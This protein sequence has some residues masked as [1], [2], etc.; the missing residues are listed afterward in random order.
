MP[1]QSY[2]IPLESIHTNAVIYEIR[3]GDVYFKDINH[4][5]E[6][7]E[8][9][10][11][12]EAVG[13]RLLDLFPSAKDIGLYDGVLKVNENGI[14]TTLKV[15]FYE[16]DRI[17]GWRENHIAKI[18]QNLLLVTYSDR[19]SEMDQE[20]QKQKEIA[21]AI[22]VEK[23]RYKAFMKLSTQAIMITDMKGRLMEFSNQVSTLFG[24]NTQELKKLHIWDWDKQI[25]IEQIESVMS[26]LTSEP[27]IFE[28]IHTRKDGS[29][30]D[31]LVTAI[32]MQTDQGAVVYSTVKDL[33]QQQ[34]V[35]TIEDY[36][37]DI[38][39]KFTKISEITSD[40]V[41]EVDCDGKFTFASSGVKKILGYESEEIIGKTPFDFMPQEEAQKISAQF[42][43]IVKEHAPI[44]DLRN[45]NIAK[46]GKKVLLLTNGVAVFEKGKFV[47]YRGTDKDITKSYEQEN[48]Y[49][50]L[51]DLA[52]DGVHILDSDGNIVECSRSFAQTLGY[53]MEEVQKLNVKDWDAAIDQEILIGML[54]D[55]MVNPQTFETKHKKRDG[56]IID[57]QISTQGLEINGKSYL[58]ASQREITE[59]VEQKKALERS[60]H[61][62]ESILQTTQD[63]FWM[64]DINSGAIIDVN[65]AYCEMI[66]YSKDELIGMLIP[67]IEVN[68]TPEETA[69]HIQTI[70]ENGSDLFETKHRKKDGTIIDVEISTSYS[71]IDGGRFFVL[72]RDIT[73]RK[74]SEAKMKLAANVFASM[75]DAILVTDANQKII[76]VNERFCTISGHRVEDVLGKN[77]SLLSSGWH[78][79]AFYAKMWRDLKQ[80]DHWSGEIVD[81]KQ[82]GEVYVCES[83]IL[84]IRDENNTITN[85]VAIQNDITQKKEHEELINNLAYYDALTKLPNRPHFEDHCNNRIAAAKRKN[86]KLAL[87]YIDLDNFKSINDTYGHVMG[88]EFLRKAAKRLKEGVRE[89]DSVGR[90]GGDE[91]A[92]LIEDFSSLSNLNTVATKIVESFR[93]PFFIEKKI[94]YSGSSIGIAIYPDDAQNYNDLMQLADTAMYEV[95]NNAKNSAAFYTASM[96]ENIT[97][98]TFIESALRSALDNGELF[99]VYQPKV[100]CDTGSVYGV[101]ALLRWSHPTLG[102]LSPEKFI[103]IAESSGVIYPIGLWVI[104]QALKDIEEINNNRQSTL[105]VSVNV[106]AVQLQ[107]SVFTQDLHRL[108]QKLNPTRTKLSLEITENQLMGKLDAVLPMLHEI[109]SM[110]VD[111]EIDDFGTG[112]SSLSYLKKLPVSTVKIDKSFVMDIHYDEDD[113][114]IVSAIISLAHALKKDVVAEGAQTQEH[115]DLLKTMGCKN[116]QG[117]YFAKPMPIDEFKEF[118][119]Q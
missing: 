90:L 7:T 66:G 109:K 36:L 110:D 75:T 3:E 89:E 94:L 56:T 19:S 23:E 53:S 119:L 28:T 96:N 101:E 55:L 12:Q 98:Q 2:L 5:V 114:M 73:Q 20:I 29:T 93:K 67:Q 37:E 49:R 59:A 48:K 78:D 104:E 105:A 111:F 113:K 52:S 108:L 72:V 22:K 85:Y 31:A 71:A 4:Q 103:P 35:K 84:V 60:L 54:N 88:D 9:I 63:G 82:S 64:V 32:K 43:K 39:N 81:R 21:K 14:A 11:K 79:K 8:N 70:M 15:T 38:R 18:A 92:I 24:Y 76:E 91:F 1:F 117:Y 77:P 65:S 83:T 80:K 87:F 107:K 10:T 27:L 17:Q 115:I 47:G 99:L 44:K 30:F 50:S 102:S 116:V 13:Q 40:W 74:K 26:K 95:K 100:N 62:Y 46:D 6:T 51:L 33:S 25:S 57:V 41:W 97:Q 86:Q 34:Y 106:S 45:W 118:L 58:Y 42:A 68:E 61:L 112:Y 69:R 16:D